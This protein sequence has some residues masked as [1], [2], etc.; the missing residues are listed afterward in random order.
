MSVLIQSFV[1]CCRKTRRSLVTRELKGCRPRPRRKAIAFWLERLI[2]SLINKLSPHERADCS[3]SAIAG[4]A[5]DLT[6]GRF[7][8]I[9]R[10]DLAA[11]ICEASDGKVETILVTRSRRFKFEITA[12]LG[13]DH[14]ASRQVDLIIG[15]DGL[16][17]RVRELV[18]GPETDFEVS[19]GYHIA[20]FEVEVFQPRDELVFVAHAVAGRQVSR[21]SLRPDKTLFLF[22]SRD[23]YL[24]GGSPINNGENPPITRSTLYGD[25]KGSETLLRNA[26]ADVGWECPQILAAMENASDVYFDRVSQI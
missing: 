15:A 18:F 1:T 17:S 10:S 9:A 3:R 5:R 26:F 16:H 4:G 7:T 12:E 20:V 13:F 24:T 6:G 22:V 8:E 23:E 11:I 19:L 2:D 14:A 25:E 21:L